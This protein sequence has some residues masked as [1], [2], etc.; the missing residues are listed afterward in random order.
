MGMDT[1]F[2]QG[3]V[4]EEAEAGQAGPNVEDLLIEF[5]RAL[6]AEQ[7]ERREPT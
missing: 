6:L 3:E 2:L 1:K 5:A 7:R 4:N